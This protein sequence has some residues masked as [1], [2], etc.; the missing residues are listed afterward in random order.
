MTV[1]LT[2][3]NELRLA[4]DAEVSNVRVADGATVVGLRW[5][6]TDDEVLALLIE[7]LQ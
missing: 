3:S 1:G 5:L 6:Q 7:E 4:L 2:M